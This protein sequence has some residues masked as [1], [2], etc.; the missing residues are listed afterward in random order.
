MSFDACSRM[1]SLPALEFWECVWETW[2][3]N[4]QYSSEC[5]ATSLH[6]RRH[7]DPLILLILPRILPCS[8]ASYSSFSSMSS[9]SS[10][11]FAF[12]LYRWS[13]PSDASHLSLGR[14][15]RFLCLFSPRQG[16]SSRL[17]HPSSALACP[18]AV[19]LLRNALSCLA[20]VLRFASTLGPLLFSSL[21][22][23][24]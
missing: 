4:R 14:D 12:C 6:V 16:H 8:F 5:A 1:D 2:K 21:Q 10:A 3:W 19:P 22:P 11:S 24:V 20:P 23:H 18:L 17:V 13:R 15:L 7:L 9:F